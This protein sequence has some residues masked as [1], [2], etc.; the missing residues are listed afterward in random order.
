MNTANYVNQSY[1]CRAEELARYL[2]EHRATVRTVAEHF[3]ISKSTVHSDITKHL[4]YCN[5]SLY[6]QAVNHPRL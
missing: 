3:G 5:Q 1:M 2:V 4:P 6:L